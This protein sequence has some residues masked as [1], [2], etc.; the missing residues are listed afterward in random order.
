MGCA[1]MVSLCAG[2]PSAQVGLVILQTDHMCVLHVNL[3]GELLLVPPCTSRMGPLAGEALRWRLQLQGQVAQG[4]TNVKL[5][6]PCP[7]SGQ[8]NTYFTNRN[9]LMC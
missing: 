1:C 6:H 7:W 5:A 4:A 9:S 3:Q 2:N 8:L